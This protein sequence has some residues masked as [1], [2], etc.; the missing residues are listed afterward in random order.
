MIKITVKV[1]VMMKKKRNRT[2]VKNIRR[3]PKGQA[4]YYS[5]RSLVEEITGTSENDLEFEKVEKRIRRLVDDLKKMTGSKG[6]DADGIPHYQKEGFVRMTRD[7]YLEGET[8]KGETTGR[9]RKYYKMMKKGEQLSDEQFRNL[10]G[11]IKEAVEANPDSP[12]KDYQLKYI[13]METL[14]LDW[15]DEVRKIMLDDINLVGELKPTPLR[16]KRMKEYLDCLTKGESLTEWRERV[17]YDLRMEQII[18]IAV[19]KGFDPEEV[20]EGK[21]L[22]QIQEIVMEIILREAK[23]DLKS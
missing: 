20:L 5:L 19:E 9:A 11:Y 8:K 3:K 15:M 14:F 13:A 4:E 16:E 1:G 12:E 23:N 17:R 18:E 21:H 10:I 6:I 2:S 7:F 22:E